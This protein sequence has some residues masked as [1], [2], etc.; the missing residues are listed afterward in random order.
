MKK[1]L[2]IALSCFFLTGLSAQTDTNYKEKH[3]CKDWVKIAPKFDDAFFKTPEAIRI[4]DNVLLYQQ[5]TGGWPKNI[6]M[7]AELTDQERK[8]ALKMKE[9]VNLST[10]DNR[11]TITEMNYLARIYL[12]TQDEKYKDAFLRGLQY[13]FEAQYENG[14]WPQFY[15]RPKGYYIHITYNDDAMINV[16]K[17]LRD[18]TK[19][20][21]P[22][23]FVPDAARQQAQVALDKGVECILKTQVKQNGKLTV[24]CAQHD[25]ETLAP[26]KAR[27]YELPSLSGQES[28]DIVL[29]LMSLSKPTPEMIA[30]IDAAIEWFKESEIK[31]IK[32][33]YFT[34][35]DGKKDYRM[36]PCTDCEPLWA[37]FYE[38]ETNRPFFC[39]R[40]GI[41]KYDISEIG[42][43]RRNGYSWYNNGGLKVLAKYKEWKKKLEK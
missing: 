26:A 43:E 6:Y 33:E 27:A 40:D 7:A 17:L 37:R 23:T 31:N 41:K 39:D 21:A 42:Y 4:A 19:A 8:D 1:I 34:N 29:F 30:S 22:Y 36:V 24:W 13:L 18:I 28:D 5:I 35:A 2:L 14:G 9:N 25:R 3:P 12:A 32:K 10:I 20:K 16:M 15:P 38:L 11:A